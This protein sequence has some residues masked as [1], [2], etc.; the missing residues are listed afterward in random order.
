MLSFYLI[1]NN[2]DHVFGGAKVDKRFSG[3]LH[4]HAEDERYVLLQGEGIVEI[5]GLQHKMRPG[6]EAY[7]EGGLNHAFISTGPEPAILMF[8]FEQGPLEDKKK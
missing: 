8:E 3:R 2:T 1:S 6:D 5:G 4:S 7:I